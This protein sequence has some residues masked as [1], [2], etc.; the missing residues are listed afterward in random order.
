MSTKI[1]IQG[2]PEWREA[3]ATK[4]TG[5]RVAAIVGAS[6]FTTEAAVMRE[7]VCESLG[8]YKDISN[9]AMRWGTEHEA[10]A[11]KLYDFL[12]AGD[13][14]I[15]TTGFWEDGIL[16][17]S[18]DALVGEDG[19]V[20]IKCP[21]KIR[22]EVDPDFKSID[23]LQH[24]WHQIQMQ[25]HCTKREWCDFFQ[26]TPN[27]QRCERVERDPLWWKVNAPTIK[28]FYKRYE[29]AL[30]DADVGGPQQKLGMG[31]RWAA[32][33]EQ[34]ATANK[35][36]KAAEADVKD[37]KQ[38]MTTMMEEVEVDTCTGGG[39]KALKILRNGSINWKNMAMDQITE[40]VVRDIE[41]DY[42]N[43]PVTSYRFDVE[44]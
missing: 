11:L 23:D 1:L 5:S 2:T 41:E 28:A 42:R 35:V 9:E 19:L 8:E 18:P 6:P 10:E 13:N 32:A 44:K 40:L 26:W 37:A 33:A 7:M 24:Y 30:A 14:E 22:D 27:G 43:A 3:R 25:L 31:A 21:W 17:A 4:V 38:R 34:Y 39:V 12:H 20:E 15:G 16:G 36:M 29:K